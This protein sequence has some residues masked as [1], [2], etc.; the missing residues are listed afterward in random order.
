MRTHIPTKQEEEEEEE[1]GMREVE[2]GGSAGRRNPCAKGLRWMRRVWGKWEQWP[3]EP[4]GSWAGRGWG[5][6]ASR[7]LNARGSYWRESPGRDG[8]Y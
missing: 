3:E 6:R 4:E 7:T 8:A 2:V 1:V 5:C